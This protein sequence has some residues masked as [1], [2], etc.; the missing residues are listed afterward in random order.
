M[1]DV[2][3]NQYLRELG[4]IPL[5]TPEEEIELGRQI[6]NGD[7]AARER[8]TEQICGSLSPLHMTMSILGCRSVI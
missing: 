1:N 8:M 2:A 6:K 3:L 7:A 4:E 5:L